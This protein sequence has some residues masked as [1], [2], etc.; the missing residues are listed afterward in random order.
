M[1]FKLPVSKL[2]KNLMAMLFRMRGW[3]GNTTNIA[4]A[5]NAKRDMPTPAA[6]N[7]ITFDSSQDPHFFDSDR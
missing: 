5:T 2:S 1:T 4:T 3:L 7:V 6:T